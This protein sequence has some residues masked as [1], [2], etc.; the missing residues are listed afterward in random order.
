L[1]TLAWAVAVQS[2][3]AAEVERQLQEAFPLVGAEYKPIRAHLH[4]L[5][6][7]A[8]SALG[9][10][11]A[12]EKSARHFQQAAAGDPEGNFGRLAQAALPE[13]AA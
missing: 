2:A 3:D 5:A 13:A 12:R 10:T 7:V 8:Y 4:Y 9:T 11:D 6:G 1:A